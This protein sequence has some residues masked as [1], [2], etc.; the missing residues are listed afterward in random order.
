MLRGGH[1]ESR[2]GGD[3]GGYRKGEG[4][5]GAIGVGGKRVGPDTDRLAV[6]PRRAASR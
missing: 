5:W 2:A 1:R 4:G 3:R 6:R